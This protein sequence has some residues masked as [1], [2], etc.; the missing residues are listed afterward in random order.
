VVAA[1]RRRAR[2][3][4]DLGHFHLVEVRAD[5]LVV[6]GAERVED[7]EDILV[8]DEDPRLAHRFRREVLVVEVLVVDLPLVHAAA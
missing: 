6:L 2:R 3:R 1:E 8:L 5:R 4:E 7:R